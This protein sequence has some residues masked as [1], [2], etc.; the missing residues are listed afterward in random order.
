MRRIL[1]AVDDSDASRRA[2][3]FVDDFFKG[4]DIS[5]VAVNVAH[6]P[7]EAIPPAPYGGAFVPPASEEASAIEEAVEREE[8]KGEA[9]AA[10]YAPMDAEIEVVFG[11]TVDAIRQAAENENADLIVV[12]SN[13]RGFLSRLFGGSV[14]ER[15]QR[16]SA[17]PVLVVP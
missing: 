10:A 11:E 12:G 3:A 2:S 5:I 14:S 8:T 16:E 4:D 9:V 6:T 1:V 7:T 15:L 17:I 13:D